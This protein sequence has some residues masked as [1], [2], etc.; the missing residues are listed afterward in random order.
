MVL[1]SR[2]IV[3]VAR[4]VS[5]EMVVPGRQVIVNCETILCGSRL[6]SRQEEAEIKGA[7]SR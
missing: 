7:F 1:V 6:Q 5:G 3:F 2:A 4:D